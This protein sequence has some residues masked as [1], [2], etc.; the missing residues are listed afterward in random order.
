MKEFEAISW[1]PSGEIKFS[2]ADLL[3]DE[4]K[5]ILHSE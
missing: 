1:N 5:I 4:K 2:L 3:P